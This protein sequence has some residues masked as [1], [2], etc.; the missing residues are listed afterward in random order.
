MLKPRSHSA[1][2]VTE[3]TILSEYAIVLRLE[4][5]TSESWVRTEA[6]STPFSDKQNVAASV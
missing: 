4:H 6:C 2:I 1:L 5:D 3:V